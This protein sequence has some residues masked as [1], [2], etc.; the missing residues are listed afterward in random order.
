VKKLILILIAF[1]VISA[2]NFLNEVI[3]INYLIHHFYDHEK[4]GSPSG[5]IG[6]LKL[7]YFDRLHEKSDRKTHDSLPLHNTSF[8]TNIVY[9]TPAESIIMETPLELN[10]A[11]LNPL[12][13]Q[14]TPQS[15]HF[16]IFQP[17][18]MS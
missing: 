18:R 2:G 12:E 11:D 9:S 8:Q 6:F 5:V 14:M 16:S 7:H 3:K 10:S 17:P 1:Q 15:S 13:K 4:Q